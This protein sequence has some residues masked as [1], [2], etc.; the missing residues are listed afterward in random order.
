ML[1][2]TAHRL[3]EIPSQYVL[4]LLY[5][6]NFTSSRKSSWKPAVTLFALCVKRKTGFSLW[7]WCWEAILLDSG[8][9][10]VP[11]PKKRR[12]RGYCQSINQ[13]QTSSTPPLLRKNVQHACCTLYSMPSLHTVWC[14]NQCSVLCFACHCTTP[15]KARH[16]HPNT[17]THTGTS[18]AAEWCTLSHI[19]ICFQSQVKI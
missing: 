5:P 14:A 13:L 1:F 19:R 10:A 4:A 12:V 11:E 3:V 16:T 17:H 8:I 9:D 15:H 6:H 7:Y 2:L 18:Q